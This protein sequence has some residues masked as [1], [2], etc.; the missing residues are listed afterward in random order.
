MSVLSLK[1]VHV[2]IQ[3]SHVL[4]GVTFE[5]PSNKVTALLGRNGVGKS[6]TLKAIMGLRQSAGEITLDGKSI[7]GKPTYQIVR[8]GIGYV[9]ED[10]EIFSMLSVKDNLNIAVRDSQP[11]FDLVYSLFPEL[12]TRTAQRA[13]TLSGGQQQMVAI[14]RALLNKNQILL[15]DEPTKGLAPKLVTEV[16]ESLARVA[17]ESTMLLVEQNLALVK[18]VAEHILIM[19][20]GKI[21]FQ[22]EPSHLEDADFVHSMLGVGGRHS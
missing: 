7:Q 21:I 10:R 8:S 12:K 22:G 6:T 16:A 14:S 11:N 17:G 9:P 19:D 18:H 2:Y 5:I 3:G 20:Q 13:G 4:R 15:I 1:D